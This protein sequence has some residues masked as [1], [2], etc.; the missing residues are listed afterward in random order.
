[1]KERELFNAAYIQL[2]YTASY[3]QHENMWEEKNDFY[4]VDKVVKNQ[5]MAYFCP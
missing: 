2:E 3:N 4:A 5:A 1:M